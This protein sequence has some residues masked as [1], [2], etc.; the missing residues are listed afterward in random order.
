MER[1][2]R[3]EMAVRMAEYELAHWG[4]LAQQRRAAYEEAERERMQAERVLA[5]ARIDLAC[6]GERQK[7][8]A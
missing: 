3:L 4:P 6:C 5:D 7:V 2:E 1:R 8:T